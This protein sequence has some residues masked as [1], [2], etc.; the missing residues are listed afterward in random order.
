MARRAALLGVPYPI[1][2][3]E[4]AAPALLFMGE[5][6]GLIPNAATMAVASLLREPRVEVMVG[7][8]HIAAIEAPSILA[9]LITAFLD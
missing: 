6:D 3:G 5:R 8:G 4:I 7:V 1:L 2:P 9:G